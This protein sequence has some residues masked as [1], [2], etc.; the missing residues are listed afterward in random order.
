[1]H[2]WN[3]LPGRHIKLPPRRQL[4]RRWQAAKRHRRVL[5]EPLESRALLAPLVNTGTAADLIFTL[6]ASASTA[7]LEDDGIPGNGVSQLRSANGTFDTTLVANP[8]GSL[9]INPGNAADTITINA[10]PDFTA[11]I[12]LGA[13]ASPL[14]S[15][16]FAG[17]MTLAADKNLTANSTGAIN[18]TTATSDIAPASTVRSR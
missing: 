3:W 5:I 16:V 15:I 11:S 7:V 4:R 2:F 1:M 10:L 17:V 18:L 9:T 13:S 8:T 14:S 6:P 12:A